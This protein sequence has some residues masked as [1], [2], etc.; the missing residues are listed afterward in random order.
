M[1]LVATHILSVDYCALNGISEV[2]SPVEYST[3]GNAYRGWG[4]G[5]GSWVGWGCTAGV[6]RG[7]K[8]PNHQLLAVRKSSSA[9][10]RIRAGWFWQAVC[11]VSCTNFSF[12]LRQ[13]LNNWVGASFHISW[14]GNSCQMFFR[15]VPPQVCQAHTI[16]DAILSLFSL[17]RLAF[18]GF[19]PSSG[20]SLSCRPH[21]FSRY[22]KWMLLLCLHQVLMKKYE[23]EEK[24]RRG[25][26]EQLASHWKLPNHVSVS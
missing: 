12:P 9:D 13:P 22:F 25:S 20:F 21:S 3:S 19:L 4:L 10:K 1:T 11:C 7:I 6:A 8:Q 2:S 17:G 5:R 15:G 16:P 23:G 18:T 26:L 14:R 24:G